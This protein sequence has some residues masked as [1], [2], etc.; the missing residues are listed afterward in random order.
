M[1]TFKNTAFIK[2]DYE[3]SNVVAYVGDDINAVK[4]A[5]PTASKVIAP[6]PDSI[7]IGLTQITMCNGVRAFG[8]L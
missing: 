5:F 7:L 4:A 6:A 8:Y 1:A 3:C 2:R